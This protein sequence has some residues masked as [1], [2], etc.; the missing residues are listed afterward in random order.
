MGVGTGA[1]TWISWSLTKGLGGG[2]ARVLVD[3]VVI[4]RI[5]GADITGWVFLCGEPIQLPTWAGC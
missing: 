4:D 3:F 5:G 1:G 2:G